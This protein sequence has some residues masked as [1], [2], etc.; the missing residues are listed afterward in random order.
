MIRKGVSTALI[1]LAV[2]AITSIPAGARP[3]KAETLRVYKNWQCNMPVKPYSFGTWACTTITMPQKMVAGK[4]ASV[5][6][7]FKAK[8]TMKYVDVCFSKMD[9]LGCAYRHKY[10]TINRG[11]TIK[12]V[13]VMKVPAASLPGSH[14]LDNYTRFYK[15]PKY[16]SK[17][18]YWIAR[19]YSCVT[20]PEQPNPQCSGGK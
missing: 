16:A 19:A 9:S 2:I 20:T 8:T 11:S 3:Y 14:L 6:F 4:T 1:L 17:D 7:Q 18:V 5:T 15:P 13:L 12:R 10:L